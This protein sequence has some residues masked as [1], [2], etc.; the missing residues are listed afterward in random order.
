MSEIRH[1]GN[2]GINYVIV[3]P[4]SF[5]SYAVAQLT[6]RNKKASEVVAVA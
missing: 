2:K 4:L 1:K 5:F 6:T 3:R